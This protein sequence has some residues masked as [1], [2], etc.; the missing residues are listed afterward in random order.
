MDILQSRS[1]SIF[2]KLDAIFKKF[3]I[4]PVLVGGYA[5][6]S[7]KIQRMT[8]D[9]DFLITTEDYL[10]VEQELLAL[11][12]SIV[13]KN[14]VFVQFKSDVFGL[15]DI[16]FLISDA[17]TVNSVLNNGRKITIAGKS[18]VVPSL[19][20]LIAMK[21]HSIAGNEEREVKDLPDVIQL[22]VVNGINPEKDEI[23]QLF[24]KYNLLEIYEKVIKAAK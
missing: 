10:K 1:S 18:F 2:E 16:D 8:F 15:R 14:E 23:K 12:Y 4:Q 22:M 20:H 11:G 19:L 17:K 6:I 7:Y 9:V 5:V 3:S 24:V 21:L 13:N